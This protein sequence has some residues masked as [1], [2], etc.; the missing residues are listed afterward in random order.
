MN[1]LAAISGFEGE[2]AALAGGRVAIVSQSSVSD[3][4][5]LSIRSS[6]QELSRTTTGDATSETLTGDNLRDTIIG[7]GGNDTL[8]GGVGADRMEGG[9]GDD[10]F[11]VD[12]PGDVV[13]ELAGEGTDTVQ[14]SLTSLVLPANVE[15]GT[16][17]VG[18]DTI[19]G[20]SG[21]N[22]LLGGLGNDTI[23]G[24]GGK[25]LTTGGGGLDRMV[26]T[27]LSDSGI[28]FAQRTWSIRSRMAIGCEGLSSTRRCQR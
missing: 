19:T 14:T 7:N 20:N 23:I 9:T 12:N 2:F 25:D 22:T 6:I 4:S 24:G 26:L 13:V 17:S 8:S 27:S 11:I 16:G 5:G 3:G 28:T 21:G 18:A 10:T 15:N 1:T